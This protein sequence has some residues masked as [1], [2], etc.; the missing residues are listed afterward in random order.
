MA[1]G[2]VP[3]YQYSGN[4]TL[5]GMDITGIVVCTLS[6]GGKLK[7]N[8]TTVRGTIVVHYVPTLLPLPATATFEMDDQSVIDG[9]TAWTGNLALLAPTVALK[10]DLGNAKIISGVVY[11]GSVSNFSNTTIRGM[12]LSRST[13]FCDQN[14]RFEP[15]AGFWPDVPLGFDPPTRTTLTWYAPTRP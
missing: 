5:T 10:A 4:T 1:S 2:A 11:V 9:G 6:N 8:R 14:V 15:P 3:V 12:L 13:V 7:L